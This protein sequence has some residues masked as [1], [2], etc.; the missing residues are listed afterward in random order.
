[1]HDMCTHRDRRFRGRG[2]EQETS[3]ARPLY[4]GKEKLD[5]PESQV[6]GAFA[7]IKLSEKLKH[8]IVLLGSSEHSLS[9][10]SLATVQRRK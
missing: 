7:H 2:S 5:P 6:P 9:I 3:E 8:Q 4:P 1:M 10:Y